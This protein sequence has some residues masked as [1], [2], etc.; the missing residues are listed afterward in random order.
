MWLDY[1]FEKVFGLTER[2]GPET[3]D[4]HYDHIADCLAQ[5]EFRPRALFERFGIEAIATTEGPLDDLRWHK[6]IRDS[7]WAGRVITAYRPDM[8]VDPEFEGFVGHVEAFGALTGC[9]VTTWD[10]YL[11][12]HRVRRAFFKEF[13]ATSSD[14]G[15][16]T[17]R[18]EDL[19]QADAAAL[20]ERVRTGRATPEEADAFRGQML[21]EMARMSLE[22]GLVLQIHAGLAA[23]PFG[24]DDGAAWPRQGLRHPGPHRLRARAEAAARRGRACARISA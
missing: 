6:A 2:F 23:Q 9:D 21:T 22:D 15:H 5:P 24:G 17:A 7:G 14:H 16:P 18:T 4:A 19:P 8:V 20:Y 13:G 3:A 11:E 1:T 10:G 12:A